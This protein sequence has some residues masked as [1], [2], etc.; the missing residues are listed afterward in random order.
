MIRKIV[1]GKVFRWTA[2]GLYAGLIFLASSRSIQVT[3]PSVPYLDKCVHFIEYGL[4]CTLLCWAISAH[5]KDGRIRKLI[6]IA[7]II[8]ALYG[9]TDEVHQLFVPARTGEVSDWLADTA[10]AAVA[11]LCWLVLFPAWKARSEKQV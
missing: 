11:G 3:A 7:I 4:F 8:T 1:T 5:L 2:I 9:I 10:G 6:F